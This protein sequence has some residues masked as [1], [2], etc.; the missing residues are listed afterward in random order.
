MTPFQDLIGVLSAFRFGPRYFSD[1]GLL[2]APCRS[3]HEAKRRTLPH[4]SDKLIRMVDTAPISTFQT[5]HNR[6]ASDQ[7]KS[8]LVIHDANRSSTTNGTSNGNKTDTYSYS[9]T[10]KKA[11]EDTGTGECDFSGLGHY[12]ADRLTGRLDCSKA[13]LA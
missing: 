13:Y 5:G 2:F 1:L 3:D 7:V 8:P 10:Y 4:T 11:A 12:F 6:K 9:Y